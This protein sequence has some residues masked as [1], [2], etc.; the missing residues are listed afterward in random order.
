MRAYLADLAVKS[1]QDGA[2]GAAGRWLLAR[3]NVVLYGIAAAAVAAALVAR[4]SLEPILRG[5]APY[6]FFVPAILVAAGIGG[7]GPGI[8]ATVLSLALCL[9]FVVDFPALSLPEIVNAGAFVAIGLGMAWGGNSCSAIACAR[10]PGR[11]P[12]WR[13]RPICNRSSIPFRT[14]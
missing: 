13:A 14:P 5:Q 7:F 12:P 3:Q 6:L 8:L 10:R 9:A 2:T 1:S 11:A 4:V